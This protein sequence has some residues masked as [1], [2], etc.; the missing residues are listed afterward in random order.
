M[1][2]MKYFLCLI[3]FLASLCNYIKAEPLQLEIKGEAAI[4]MNA[5]TGAILFEKNA[6][7]LHYPASTTKVATALYVLKTRGQELDTP[8][9]AVQ[10]DLASI[11]HEAKRRSNYT[12]PAYWLEPDGSHIGIKRD[13]ELTVRDLLKGMLIPSGNDAANVV[14]HFAGG[15]I[16]LFM[17]N[18]NVFLKDLGCTDTTFYNPHGLHHPQ[19]QTTAYDLALILKESLKHPVFCEIIS[20]TR[21][22][23]PKTNKQKSTILYQTNRLLRPGKFYYSKAIGGKTG[24][25]SKAKKAFV[26]A[27]R[28]NDRTLIIVLL[29]YDER[30][31]LYQDAITLF[32]AAFN[33]PKVHHIL[34]KAGKKKFTQ[35]L[36][37]AAEPLETY[38]AEDV[39]L[40]YYPSEDPKAK[41]HLHWH[42]LSLPIVK[43]QEVG[44]LRLISENGV[45][46]QKRNIF[47]F[48]EVEMQWPYNWFHSISLFLESSSLLFWIATI[49]MICLVLFIGSRVFRS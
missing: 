37:N 1:I 46:L 49:F 27:A 2:I 6:H 5:D 16:P 31:Q 3:I 25:H 36:P 34:L 17:E 21:F 22:V 12:L 32:D 43:D 40:D 15:T 26:G 4:L 9:I 18:L 28:Y 39:S 44:E 10:D 30:S 48:K 20:H 47:A 13:E 7:A 24:Y 23:R 38:L 45:L 19:H 41:C 8:V 11:D 33:Q 14:A 29:K 35:L 42:P